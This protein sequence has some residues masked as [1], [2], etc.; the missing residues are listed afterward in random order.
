MS[1]IVLLGDLHYGV[2]QDSDYFHNSKKLFLDNILFPYIKNNNIKHI[3]QVGDL[4]DVRKYITTKTL[5]RVRM[6]FFNPLIELGVNVHLLVGNH[7]TFYKNTIDLNSINESTH[8]KYSFNIHNTPNIIH[9]DDY[10]LLLLPWI[11]DNNRELSMQTIQD[12]KAKVAIGHLELSGFKMYKDSLISHGDSREIFNQY[13]FVFSGH[14]HTRSTDGSI[15]Y[16]GTPCQYTWSDY[17]DDKGFTIFNPKTDKIQF[18]KNHYNVFEKII[19]NDSDK[20]F[21]Y[22]TSNVDYTRYKNK[23]VKVVKKV[24]NN[25]NWVDIL[26]ENL[27]KN[28]VY[29]VQVVDDHLNLNVI[30]DTEFINVEDTWSFITSCI[31]NI[32]DNIDKESLTSEF[33]NLYLQSIGNVN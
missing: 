5:N 19:Y 21:D 32:T 11:C 27:I 23:I 9:I 7:D 15:F 29:Q 4:F 12:A 1:D 22:I 14:F 8:G 2:R 17:N 25:Q 20:K 16:I 13:K 18:I 28:D 30:D 31:N 24:V 33:Y 10:P 3:I 6:D 26:I